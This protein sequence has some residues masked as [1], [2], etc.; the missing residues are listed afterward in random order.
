MAARRGYA[1]GPYGQ[2]HFLDTGAG[3]PLVLCHQAPMSLRQFDSVYELLADSGIRAIGV[4]MP[5][6]GASDPT[7]FVPGIEDYA[8]VVPSVLDHLNISAAFILGH[9]TG[10]LVATEVSL[11]FPKR[12]I[13]VI[14]NGPLPLTAEERA[15]GLAYV[16]EF[17]KGFQHK[18]DGSHLLTMFNNRMVYASDQTDWQLATRYIAEQLIGLGPFWYGHHAAFQYDHAKTLPLMTHPTLVLTNTGDAIYKNAKDTMEMRPD[19]DF[20][21]LD[22]GTIDIVDEKPKEWVAEVAKFVRRISDT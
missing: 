14:L 15:G 11:Q 2:V 16:E 17:E 10:A 8:R 9:H 19:F 18:A 5:G 20:A 12:V 13:G 3:I 7:D 22:G 1:T 21:E 6:F 4:D